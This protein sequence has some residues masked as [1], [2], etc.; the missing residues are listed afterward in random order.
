VRTK[1]FRVCRSGKTIDGR[2]ITPDQITQMADSYNPELY[3]ARVNVEHLR[4]IMPDSDLQALGDVVAV[5]ARDEA[6]GTRG[7]YAQID[8][9]PELVR[10]AANRDKVYW[11]AE[12]HPAMPQTGGAYLCALAVTDTPASLGTEMLKF[13]IAHTP[14]M[15]PEAARSHLYSEAVEVSGPLEI[16]ATAPQPGLPVVPALSSDTGPGLIDRVRTMLTGQDRKTDARLGGLES[17]TVE[18]AAAVGGLRTDLHTLVTGLTAGTS[19]PAPAA[20]PPS[21]PPATAAGAL[22]STAAP[23]APSAPPPADPVAAL[24]A[25]VTAL[26]QALAQTPAFAGRP[27][28]AGNASTSQTTDC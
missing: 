27:L 6:D 21:Q 4:S 28:S 17:A 2:E 3:G 12:M 19:S 10:M 22:S 14:A 15:L 7:L 5:Q 20:N 26:T 1:W 8:A 11:S 13:S 25:Q 24:S 23:A 18:I 9:K 16:E